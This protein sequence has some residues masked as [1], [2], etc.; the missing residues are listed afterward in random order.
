MT[1]L[2][3]LMVLPVLSPNKKAK[4]A[5]ETGWMSYRRRS[6]RDRGAPVQPGRELSQVSSPF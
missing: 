6:Q 3:E 4:F 5:A 2:A 1:E